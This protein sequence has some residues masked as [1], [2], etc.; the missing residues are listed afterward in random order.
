MSLHIDIVVVLGRTSASISRGKAGDGGGM[1][2]RGSAT[3]L[4]VREAAEN[5]LFA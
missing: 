4:M 3:T 1:G 5:G 2:A